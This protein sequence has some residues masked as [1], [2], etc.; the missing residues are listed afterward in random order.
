MLSCALLLLLVGL[1]L[2]ARP[3]SRGAQA[4]DGDRTRDEPH[5]AAAARPPCHVAGATWESLAFF[6]RSR[7]K[8]ARPG[9]MRRS[10]FDPGPFE[11]DLLGNNSLHLPQPAHALLDELSRHLVARTPCARAEGATVSLMCPALE[12]RLGR[13]LALVA[14]SLRRGVTHHEP[15][16]CAGAFLDMDC[17]HHEFHNTPGVVLEQITALRRELR[18]RALALGFEPERVRFLACEHVAILP[19]KVFP[20]AFFDLLY[21]L[22]LPDPCAQELELAC[23]ARAAEADL[24]ALRLRSADAARREAAALP[25]PVV[26]RSKVTARLNMTNGGYEEDVVDT[27]LPALAAGY[28]RMRTIVPLAR[29]AWRQGASA[30]AV[31]VAVYVRT[32]GGRHG[33]PELFYVQALELLKQ[34]L[35]RACEHRREPCA[36]PRLS[37]HAYTDYPSSHCCAAIERWGERARARV[38]THVDVNRAL[39]YH[40]LMSA[41]VLLTGETKVAALIGRVSNHTALFLDGNPEPGVRVRRSRYTRWPWQGRTVRAARVEWAPTCV[42][43]TGALY[44]MSRVARYNCTPGAE[45]AG[46][47]PQ[48]LQITRAALRSLLLS[49]RAI[50]PAP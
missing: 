42:R 17:P 12:A 32:G 25:P 13:A 18:R 33:A 26:L 34:Q 22:L 29:P 47:S 28:A 5:A 15:G 37:V 38:V 20:S 16:F 27:E 43:A 1:A 41:D 31:V 49:R 4:P 48:A 6:V 19:S 7:T 36:A 2:R 44:A 9:W 39:Q 35:E 40:A 46:L 14:E 50:G 45:Q 8:L 24:D 30:G 21:G 3:S 10:P 11:S 23:G